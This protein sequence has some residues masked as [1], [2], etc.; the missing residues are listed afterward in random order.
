[1]RNSIDEALRYKAMPFPKP[2]WPVHL[3]GQYFVDDILKAA[4]KWPMSLPMSQLR[5][6]GDGTAR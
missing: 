5:R 1:M 6:K 2:S 3:A 4:I